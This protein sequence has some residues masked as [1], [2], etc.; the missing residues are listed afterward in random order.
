VAARAGAN[1]APS[2]LEAFAANRRV[3]WYLEP[4]LSFAECPSVAAL[5]RAGEHVSA[6]L[7]AAVLADNERAV[8]A[9]LQVLTDDELAYESA[10]DGGWAPIHAVDMLVALGAHVAIEPMLERL[11][12]GDFDEIL[13]SRIVVRL[14]QLGA[15]VLEPAL[16]L[17]GRATAPDVQHSL[18][19]VIA[20][21][22]VRDE[23]I[24]AVLRELF[25][26]DPIRTACCLAEYGDLRGLDLLHGAIMNFE[27]DYSCVGNR[28]DFQCLV[29]QYKVLGTSMPDALAEH[30]A[31][32]ERHWELA[33]NRERSP[34]VRSTGVK[35]GRNDLCP[36]GSGKKYKKCCLG[37]ARI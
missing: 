25:E 32:L 26:T 37:K 28:C 3:E 33:L 6:N 7:R 5:C 31:E 13:H 8:P 21:L 10:P 36:C 14:P 23:R 35:L 19:C 11:T 24:Y 12:S 1:T 27:T 22:G 18:S 9:L 30:V 15:A 16:A 34:T 17:I 4:M 20:A 2:R 29:E